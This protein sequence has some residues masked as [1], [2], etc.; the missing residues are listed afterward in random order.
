MLIN[1]INLIIS[2]VIAIMIVFNKTKFLGW[3]EFNNCFRH[4]AASVG[5]ADG[6]G[7]RACAVALTVGFFCSS[8]PSHLLTS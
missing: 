7:V 8:S 1:L 2:D 6:W 5:H 3:N 4:D